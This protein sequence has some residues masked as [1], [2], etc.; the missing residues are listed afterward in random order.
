MICGNQHPTLLS[1][2]VRFNDSVYRNGLECM[3]VELS[4]YDI[5][6]HEGIVYAMMNTASLSN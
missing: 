2:R 3:C 5:K 6:L 4:P 1:Q